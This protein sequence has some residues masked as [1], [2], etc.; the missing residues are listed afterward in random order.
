[1]G[2]DDFYSTTGLGY[3]VKFGNESHH[4]RNVLNH[5][6][7]DD[8]IEFVF[9]KGVWHVAKIVNYISARAW[10]GVDSDR[11]RVLVL[12]AA[13]I[14]N[15]FLGEGGSRGWSGD[16]HGEKLLAMPIEEACK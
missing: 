12:A 3:A 8:L 10:I 11:A 1:M 15:L 9:L 13:H 14:E 4:V 16:G 5:V 2:S 6:P 7:A